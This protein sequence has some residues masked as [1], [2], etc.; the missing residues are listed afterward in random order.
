MVQ[1][2]NRTNQHKLPENVN[3]VN[4]VPI[5]IEA[6]LQ[7]LNGSPNSHFVPSVFSS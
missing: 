7:I 1:K 5:S 6:F 3:G 2:Q 4:F